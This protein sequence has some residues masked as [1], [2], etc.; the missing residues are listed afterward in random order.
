MRVPQA[1]S[2]GGTRLVSRAVQLQ[3]AAR[4]VTKALAKP[5][6]SYCAGAGPLDIGRPHSLLIYPAV[7]GP[8]S[9][10]CDTRS[11][12]IPESGPRDRAPD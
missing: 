4:L 12:L 1:R 8:P 11:T 7:L 10:S 9:G 6:V 2:V 3:R 5:E